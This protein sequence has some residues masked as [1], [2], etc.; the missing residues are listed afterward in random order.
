MDLILTLL[1]GVMKIMKLVGSDISKVIIYD[2]VGDISTTKILK[3]LQY[4]VL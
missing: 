2:L 4:K 1:G 3:T